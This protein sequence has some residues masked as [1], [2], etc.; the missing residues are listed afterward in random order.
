[1]HSKTKVYGRSLLSYQNLTTFFPQQQHPVLHE[2]RTYA[3][4]DNGPDPPD[5]S[6]VMATYRYLKACNLIFENGFLSRKFISSSHDEPLQS[7]SE[8][9][10]FFRDWLDECEG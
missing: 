5:A 8:G 6:N 9:M 3:N 4:P 7:I 10:E 1:M 2:L